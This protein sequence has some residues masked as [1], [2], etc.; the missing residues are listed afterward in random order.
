[1]AETEGSV[2]GGM[3]KYQPTSAS[4]ATFRKDKV[5]PLFAKLWA[6]FTPPGVLNVIGTGSWRWRRHLSKTL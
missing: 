4:A 5:M 3:I 1:M 2:V 6:D